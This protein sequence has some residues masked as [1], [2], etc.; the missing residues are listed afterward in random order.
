MEE[1]VLILDFGGQ[2]D[3]LIARRVR[4]C[5]VYCEVMPWQTSLK[6]IEAFRPAAIIFTGG[7]HSVYAP[8]AP[9]VDP[10]VFALGVPILGICYGCQLL[11]ARLGGEVSPA[12]ESAA[13]EYGKTET[14]FSLD[15]PL[16][17]GLPEKSVTWMSH[18][19]FISR[20]PASFRAAARS[21]VCPTAA[22][23]DEVRRF[24]GV[25]FHPEV[26]H[27]E[28]GTAIGP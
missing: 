26:R 24:Y 22:I 1:K 3:Q 19:D 25:Q 9:D 10:G 23:C 8:G 16:F 27:T 28:Y 20:L 15:C 2:Y 21:E 5:A 14:A 4:E 11:A 7:P 12:R 18:G 6:E 13:R 17:R